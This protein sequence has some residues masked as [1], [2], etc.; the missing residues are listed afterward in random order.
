MSLMGIDV[1][2]T[3]CKAAVF[4]E[5]GGVLA[6][7][8]TEYDIAHPE[9]R[10]AELDAATVWEQIKG[11]IRETARASE[12]ADDLK[13][14]AVTSMGE[15]FVPVTRDRAILGPSILNIDYRGEQYLSELR[16]TCPNENLFRINGNVWGNQYSLPKLIWIREHQRELYDHTYKF[17][18]WASFVTFMLGSDPYI[19]HSL[20]NRSMLFDLSSRD[21]SPELLAL[22]KIDREKLPDTVPSGTP[23]GAV[24]TAAA[25]DLFIPA[26]TTLVSGAHDQCANALGCGVTE[27][28]MAMYGMGTFPTIAPVYTTRPKQNVMID[29]GL[30]TEHHAVPDRFVSFIFHMGGSAIKWYRDTFAAEDHRAAQAQGMEI[31]DALFAELPDEPTE[32]IVLPRFAPM[33]PPRFEETPYGAIL[34]LSL[35]TSRGAILKAILEANTMALHLVVA[36]L[37]RAGITIDRITVVGGGSRSDAHVQIAADILGKELVRSDVT[38]A[39]AFGAAL[40][41]GIGTELYDGFADV[42]QMLKKHAGRVFEPDARRNTRY[43]EKFARYKELRAFV[44]TLTENTQ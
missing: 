8:Y 24:S 15:N 3:G 32:L 12:A 27:A 25:R 35:E 36:Q 34:G 23:I 16:A 1:G 19:D 30:N 31:Y 44:A 28:N 9:P 18:H 42:A 5:S 4:D 41:A 38:E 29:L 37:P 40:L 2:T 26:G 11:V 21:W 22:G 14:I 6:L 7:R 20:A 43:E 39:G 10:T 33:G 17:L 13:G